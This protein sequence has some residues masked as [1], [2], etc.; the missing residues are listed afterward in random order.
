MKVGLPLLKNVVTLLAKIV[1][2][3]LKIT[4]TA[5]ATDTA[6]QKKVF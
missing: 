5:S 2:M 3:S 1:L 6:V 4:A